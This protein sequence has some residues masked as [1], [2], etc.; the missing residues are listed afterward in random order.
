MYSLS[1]F[2]DVP[3]WEPL[4]SVNAFGDVLSK[5]SGRILKVRKDKYGYLSFSSRINGR[6]GFWKFF[7]VH[8]LVA[9]T[10]ISN[11]QNKPHVNHKD[12]VKENCSVWNLEWVTPIENLN[13]AIQTGL[14]DPVG[15]GRKSR[16]SLRCLSI[17]V[18]KELKKE[19]RDGNKS[20][21]KLAKDYGLQRT[22]ILQIKRGITYGD[23]E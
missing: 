11:P 23:I 20:L 7:R 18:V 8:R 2:L 10:F 3:G 4:F 9:L 14:L 6:N 16:K 1:Y 12:G 13:H 19:L 21:Y 17:A 22:I 5:R 15:A